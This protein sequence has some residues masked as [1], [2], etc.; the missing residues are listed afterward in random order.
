M[1]NLA[2]LFV[3][4]TNNILVHV[5]VCFHLYIPGSVPIPVGMLYCTYLRV[6]VSMSVVRW[7]WTR[8]NHPP[9][10]DD[11]RLTGHRVEWSVIT[12]VLLTLHTNAI[13]LALDFLHLLPL[14]ISFSLFPILRYIL[15][16][17]SLLSKLFLLNSLNVYPLQF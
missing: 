13:F 6:Y 12:A 9:Q 7:V 4:Y 3:L 11:K 2:R 1:C 5:W 15:A 8:A 14:F 10:L 17:F 16:N